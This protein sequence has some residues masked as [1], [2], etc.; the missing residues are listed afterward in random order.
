[1]TVR[2]SLVLTFTLTIP[3]TSSAELILD[4]V[5]DS[6]NYDGLFF[7]DQGYQRSSPGLSSGA[8]AT[9]IGNGEILQSITGVFAHESS[10][11][12]INGGRPENFSFRFM[13]HPSLASYVADPFLF[14]PESGEVVAEFGQVSNDTDWLEVRG[15]SNH[16]H[17]LFHWTLD[18]EHLA[19]RTLPNAT[20]L[21]TLLPIA[22][23]ASGPSLLSFSNGHTAIGSTDHWFTTPLLGPDTLDNLGAPHHFTAYRVTTSVPEPSSVLLLTLCALICT[24]LRTGK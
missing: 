7:V 18:I 21:V 6:T 16:G 5:T 9:I 8:A 24:L 3:L 20:H 4:H 14:T 23:F 15:T 1:M 11:G 2:T 12:V 10:D 13:F 17:H 22:G 19:I